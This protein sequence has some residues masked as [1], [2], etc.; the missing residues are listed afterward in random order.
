MDP[1]ERHSLPDAELKAVDPGALAKV[2][3]LGQAL[4]GLLI[5]LCGLQLVSLHSRF[6]ILNALPY[7]LML[8]GVALIVLAAQVY[9]VRVWAACVAAGL[10]PLLTLIMSAWVIVAFA[11]VFSCLVMVTM[12]CVPLTSIL[13]VLAIGGVRRAAAARA[14]LDAAGMGLGL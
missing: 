7:V 14:K 11:E 8:S 12:P 10:T 9:R 6:A 1:L 4:S 3:A 2:G 5:A 13:G